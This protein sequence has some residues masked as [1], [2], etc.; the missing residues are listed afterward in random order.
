MLNNK[1]MIALHLKRLGLTPDEAKVY[2]ALL[3][4]PMSHLEIARKSSVNRT[5]VYRIADSLIKRGLISEVMNDE[6]RELAAAD[7]A[8]LEIALTTAE[9]KLKTQR[10]IFKQ[11]LPTLQQ[12][13]D[14][15]GQADP[16][17]FIVNTYE[18]HGGFKQMLWNELKAQKEIL[19]FGYGTIQ[20]LITSLRWAEQHRIKTIEAGYTIREILNPGGKQPS[21]T[22][23]AEFM[24]KIYQCR[25]IDSKILLL[26]Q[27][28]CIYNDTVATYCWRNDQK[29]GLEVVNQAHAQM[30][31]QV[32]EHYWVLAG[33]LHKTKT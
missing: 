2:L 28:I 8:N 21:F 17:D 33:T 30:M 12:L 31:R 29:V 15:R 18:G 7:P 1:N 24:E 20:D 11:T 5:K 16:N 3:D 19:I 4:E 13:F 25:Y 32:F 27:Q 6:G 22:A 10:Q 23:N 26:A 14:A 9:E